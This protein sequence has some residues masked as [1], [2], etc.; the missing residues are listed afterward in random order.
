MGQEGD[1]HLATPFMAELAV[2]TGARI[3][4][5]GWANQDGVSTWSVPTG[6][7]FVAVCYHHSRKTGRNG[8]IRRRFILCA[9]V[10]YETITVGI[11]QEGK[12]LA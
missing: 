7:L 12:I 4:A 1:D 3:A 8:I 6:A 9:H 2:C 11:A 5:L 10:N